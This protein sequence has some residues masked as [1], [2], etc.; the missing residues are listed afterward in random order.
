MEPGNLAALRNRAIANLQNNRLPAALKDYETLRKH[1]PRTHAVYY[2]LG[3]I[4]YRR[5]ETQAAVKNYELYLKYAPAEGSPEQKEEKQLVT[6]RL[7]ELKA[8]AR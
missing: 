1:M 8:A 7:K 4:A 3:E 2:G 5:K 6:N